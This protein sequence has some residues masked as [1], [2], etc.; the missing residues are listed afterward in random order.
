MQE[1]FKVKPSTTQ[2]IF[3]VPK[4]QFIAQGLSL[5][6]W[7]EKFSEFSLEIV[8]LCL[9]FCLVIFNAVI[10]LFQ[11]QKK[12]NGWKIR[13]WIAQILNW[14]ES[15]AARSKSETFKW[16]W[17]S[18]VCRLSK[19]CLSYWPNTSKRNESDTGRY[20]DGIRSK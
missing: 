4:L 19:S 11:I 13:R 8:H 7:Y 5:R 10:F 2:R 18:K 9:F 12:S 1:T 20:K 15:F 3:L 16:Q 14:S 17:H 6:L